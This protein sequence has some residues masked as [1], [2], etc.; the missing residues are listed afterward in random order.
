[1]DNEKGFF[2]QAHPHIAQVIGMAV[3]ELLADEAEVSR[4]S[5]A[6]MIRLLYQGK[7]V[8]LAVEL[9]IDVLRLPPES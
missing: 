5:I 7:D 4:E 1:M 9:A 3:I 2:E 8:D 6:E